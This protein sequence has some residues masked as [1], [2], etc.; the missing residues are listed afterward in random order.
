MA[1]SELPVQDGLVLQPFRGVRYVLDN[2]AQVTSPPYDLV[3]DSDIL[4]LLALHPANVV[5]LILPGPDHHRYAEARDTLRS[6][7]ASGLLAA[8]DQPA[9][10]VYEQCTATDTHSAVRPTAQHASTSDIPLA[11]L[12]LHKTHRHR[13]MDGH[14]TLPEHHA[15]PPASP[16]GSRPLRSGH[17]FQTEGRPG[18]PSTSEAAS[19]AASERRVLQRGLIGAVALTDPR[20][21]I[22]LPHENVMP[23]PVADRL[24]LMRAAEANLEPIFLLYDGGGPAS[25]LVD[26]IA[27]TRPPLIE[28]V[29]DD[30]I[31]HRLW[32]VTEQPKLDLIAAD[33]HD[34]QALIADGHHRYATYR[35]LQQEYHAS[36]HGNGP[37]DSGLALLVDSAV[38][39]PDLKPIHRVIPALPLAEA[40]AKAKGA[41]QVHEYP[42]LHE[43]LTALASCHGIAFLLA[44]DG[45]SHLLTDP[46]ALQ[47]ERAMPD[48]RSERWRSLN[49]SILA[50][51]VFPKVWGIRDDEESV[52]IVHHDPYAAEDLARQAGGTAVVLQPLAVDAVSAVAAEGE[53]VPRKSTSFGPKPRTGL[54]MR[55]FATD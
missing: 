2:L 54:V 24:A 39:A 31:R 49:T 4:D 27:T 13:P 35:A 1:S 8:D 25:H 20:Q 9:I 53:R 34:R 23:G 29:T 26:E 7:L 37:W 51:F 40:V 48:D 47:L 52:R 44:G 43:G 15:A 5:R 22:V 14:G 30:G 42:T 16:E 21:G 10:Y 19:E 17:A 55:T 50:E 11:D 45:S 32:A 28:A 38:Y 36:G 6:W 41:W 12:S 46:D 33:L 18:A 3:S